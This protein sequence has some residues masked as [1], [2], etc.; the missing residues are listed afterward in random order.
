[1]NYKDESVRDLQRIYTNRITEI[2]IERPI[3]EV[4]ERPTTNTSIDEKVNNY[5]YDRRYNVVSPD[6][7]ASNTHTRKESTISHPGGSMK[8]MRLSYLSPKGAEE[9]RLPSSVIKP[10]PAPAQLR[11]ESTVQKVQII[12]DYNEIAP[13]S[14]DD[15]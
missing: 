12:D 5:L 2:P 8:K 9:R 1:M 6:A 11:V 3:A 10:V 4:I 13:I 15:N 7:S 14:S